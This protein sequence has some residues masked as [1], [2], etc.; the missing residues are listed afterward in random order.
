[1]YIHNVRYGFAT[2]SSSTHSIVVFKTKRNVPDNT[3][4]AEFGWDFFTAGTER[5]KRQYMGQV[6]KQGLT[7]VHSLSDDDASLL[8]SKWVGEPIDA[9]GYID[10]QSI[11]ALPT[12]KDWS[13]LAL[14]K[15]FF[16]DL[17]NFVI[18]PEV[19][20]LGG[21]DNT[22]EEHP[23]KDDDVMLES[24]SHYRDKDI[25]NIGLNFFLEHNEKNLRAKY[26]KAG[27]FWT[28]FDKE[29]GQKVR[30]S[31]GKADPSKS[32]APDLVDIKITDYCAE[33]C[34]YC[35]QGSTKRG[36]HA[37]LKFIEETIKSLSALDVFEVAIG[38]GEPTE[39]PDLLRILESCNR[40]DIKP[41]LSTRNPNWIAEHY[42]QI[43]EIIG[44]IG[45]SVDT[46]TDCKNKLNILK[47]IMERGLRVTVQVAVGSCSQETLVE[48]IRACEEYKVSILLLGWKETHRGKT[49][50]KHD[51]DLYQVMKSFV[52]ETQKFPNGESY[53][54]WN[55]PHV[56]FDTVLVNETKG[57]LEEFGK[58]WMFT[59]KE[60]AHSMYIDCVSKQ[61]SRSSYELDKNLV[62]IH[63]PQSIRPET[64]SEFFAKI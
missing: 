32:D 57:W 23:L 51:V 31:F 24:G 61:M 49:A 6:V 2:N 38:G 59:T 28:I 14:R 64:I 30:L 27:L 55:G 37:E 33:G 44:A 25:N 53:T 10:H 29:S 50:K 42:D 47:P 26:N 21:N 22:E 5:T 12:K 15:D 4:G 46:V 19:A 63:S 18:R 56:G 20:I 17:L 41:S 8:A 60:G 45:L 1:M 16:Q 48:I 39:H 35:Y 40:Y 7:R 36:T 9:G 34:T 52:G 13:R 58:P 3:Y 54:P 11:I 43:K 62:N